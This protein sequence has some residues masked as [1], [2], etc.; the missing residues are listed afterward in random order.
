MGGFTKCPNC[1]KQLV[2]VPLK[3]EGDLLVCPFCESVY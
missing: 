2:E 3:L 1:I